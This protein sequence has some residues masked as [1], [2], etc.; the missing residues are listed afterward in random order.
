MTYGDIMLDP[1]NY[2]KI[3][4][5]KI[6][7]TNSPSIRAVVGVN[8][9]ADPYRGA[10]VYLDSDEMVERIVEKP[11]RGTAAT[12]WNNAGLFLFDPLIFDYTARLVPSERGELE[13]PDA[14]TAMIAD[15]HRVL[16]LPLE[17]RWRDVGTLDDYAAINADQGAN[18]L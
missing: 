6:A 1:A 16:G 10:A 4:N 5:S 14:I 2:A 9:M 11:L 18:E 7:K 12:H 17:G 8:W 13:L 15:G 3:A